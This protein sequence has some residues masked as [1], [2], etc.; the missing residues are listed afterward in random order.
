MGLWVRVRG[1][2]LAGLVLGGVVVGSGL[3]SL[4]TADSAVAQTASS[5]IVEG[6]RR[7]EAET[8][9]RRLIEL[10][11][12]EVVSAAFDSI[13]KMIAARQRRLQ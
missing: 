8:A 2:A 5:I 12:G 7:V 1:L 10:A 13:I 11:G 4:V 9:V 3:A 6:N